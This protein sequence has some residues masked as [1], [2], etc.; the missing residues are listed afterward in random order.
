MTRDSRRSFLLVGGYSDALQ[1]NRIRPMSDWGSS[2]PPTI[3]N[4]PQNH[5]RNIGASGI[6]KLTVAESHFVSA[7]ARR[8]GE[9]PDDP[10]QLV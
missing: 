5:C 6:K 8:L 10:Y 4:D 9:A 2:G 7:R 1:H 3:G